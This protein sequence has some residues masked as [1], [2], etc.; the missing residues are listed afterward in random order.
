MQSSTVKTVIRPMV[1]VFA[2][3]EVDQVNGRT[4]LEYAPGQNG[5][6]RTSLLWLLLVNNRVPILAQ[7]T[8]D[9]RHFTVAQRLLSV[10]KI[11]LSRFETCTNEIV[12]TESVSH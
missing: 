5:T 8:H 12:M 3:F 1:S 10:P 6:C 11:V 2:S 9:S 7:A 4:K